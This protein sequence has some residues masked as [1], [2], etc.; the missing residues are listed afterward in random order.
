MWTLSFF[1]LLHP[2]VLL[3]ILHFVIM[4]NTVCGLILHRKDHFSALVLL[5]LSISMLSFFNALFLS[6]R[7]HFFFFFCQE[8]PSNVCKFHSCSASCSKDFQSALFYF[9]LSFDLLIFKPIWRSQILKSFRSV[10]VCAHRFMSERS[11]F[12]SHFLIITSK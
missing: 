11:I 9:F 6:L 4:R 12:K 3:F 7:N 8:N 1:L 2:F 5:S 10:C